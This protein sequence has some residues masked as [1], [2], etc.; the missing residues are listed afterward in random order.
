MDKRK[1]NERRKKP[2]LCDKINFRKPV[3]QWA[4]DMQH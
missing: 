4:L 3:K 1:K 2:R